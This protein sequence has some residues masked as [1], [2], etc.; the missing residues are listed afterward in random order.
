MAISDQNDN[1]RVRFAPPGRGL[2]YLVF[3]H[4]SKRKIHLHVSSV[5]MYPS[6]EPLNYFF[7]SLIPWRTLCLTHT[8][9]S[10]KI[11]I[12]F[13]STLE[14]FKPSL[15]FFVFVPI[16]SRVVVVGSWKVRGAVGTL[17]FE[18]VSFDYSFPSSWLSLATHF[19]P[20]HML[21]FKGRYFIF[22]A[23]R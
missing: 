2:F 17:M 21:S 4:S 3:R 14:R 15:R 11:E 6:N 13:R 23:C 22:Y 8:D 5:V 1:Y 9:Y 18:I 7:C 12:L 16:D 20:Y 19:H 10:Q